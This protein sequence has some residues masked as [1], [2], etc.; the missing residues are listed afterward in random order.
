MGL[1]NFHLKTGLAFARGAISE[2]WGDEAEI[3]EVVKW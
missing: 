3:G 2:C 1:M